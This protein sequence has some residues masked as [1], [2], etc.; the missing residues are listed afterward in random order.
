M[1]TT[2]VSNKKRKHTE[3]SSAIIVR[4]SYGSEPLEYLPENKHTAVFAIH[5]FAQLPQKRNEKIKTTSVQVSGHQFRLMIYPRGYKKNDSKTDAEEYVSIYL[6]YKGE[7][8]EANPVN[9]RYQFRSNTT[10]SQFS[11]RKFLVSHTWGCPNFQK[12]EYIIEKDLDSKGTLAIEVDI[13]IGTPKREIWFPKLNTVENKLLSSLYHSMETTSDVTFRV[14]PG[15]VELKAHTNILSVGAPALYDLISA[16]T[17]TED[18]DSIVLQDMDAVAFQA[19]LEFIYTNKLPEL[20]N[21]DEDD[22]D[23]KEDGEDDDTE[24]DNEEDETESRATSIVTVADR[25][26]C[27]PLKLYM[28]SC[29]IQAVLRPSTNLAR[30]LLFADSHSCALLKEACMRLYVTDPAAVQDSNEEDWHRL[31]ESNALLVELLNYGTYPGRRKQYVAAWVQDDDGTI[32][33]ADAYDVTS[34]R[35]RLEQYQLDT[36]GS[37]EMLL[38][39]WKEHLVVAT[40][41]VL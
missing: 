32:Q 24:E 16:T 9:I 40:A 35:E 27:T 29:L 12:R 28:E 1:T 21:D 5:N 13:T 33:E 18:E 8:T 11:E 38:Q 31:T 20:K 23:G 25:F 17:T 30:L 4:G 3:D 6:S 37:H 39:R 2:A 26:G 15:R 14:G 34:L 36:D 41:P 7:N 19:M 22:S 10:T